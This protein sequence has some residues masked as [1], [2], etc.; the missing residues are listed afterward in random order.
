MIDHYHDYV[1][2]LEERSGGQQQAPLLDD[3]SFIFETVR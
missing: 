2:S 3:S 1:S